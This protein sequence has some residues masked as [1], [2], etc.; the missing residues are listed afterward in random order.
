MLKS[1]YLTV[2]HSDVLE[3]VNKWTHLTCALESRRLRNLRG[4]LVTA[5]V[6]L[7]SLSPAS[8]LVKLSFQET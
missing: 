4:R 5:E 8:D 2:E 6:S 1:L 3:Q 7:S